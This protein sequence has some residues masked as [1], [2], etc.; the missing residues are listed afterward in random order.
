M[1]HL[2]Y[3]ETYLLE[4]GGY[5]TAGEIEGQPELWD[6]TSKSFFEQ[7]EGFR[8]FWRNACAKADEVILTGAGTSSFIGLSLEGLFFR[9]TGLVCRAVP[10]THI[11]SHPE[12]YFSK[13][14]TPLIVSFARSGNSP[15][16]CAALEAADAFS[17]SC[18]HLIITCDGE[19]SLAMYRS[20]HPVYT[21]LLPT[22]ANDKGLAMTG[23]YSS[24][25]L[26][27][28]LAACHTQPSYAEDQI[29]AQHEAARMV[30]TE[31][32]AQIQRI[33]SW[34]FKRAVFLGSGELFGTAEEAAL[35][36]QELT[37]GKIICKADTYLGFRHGPKAVIDAATLVV[38]F[39]NGNENVRRY[40]TDLLRTMGRGTRALFQLGISACPVDSGEL[41]ELIL[42][43]APV[44]M[45]E[46][47]MPL[48]AIVAAQLLAFFKSLQ[49]GLSPDNPSVSGAIS[50]VVEGVRI[51]PFTPPTEDI[52][53][54]VD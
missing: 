2:S 23:S 5:M 11:V 34:D 46:D 41:N 54:P 40:E 38:Y 51:Y 18:F 44:K 13:E 27:G 1:N 43:E 42:L 31:K 33:A 37:D 16:S 24:M 21:I 26:T 48:S 9:R 22:G 12:N 19:G 25:L 29:L 36:L 6:L 7:L 30:L 39:F 49:L 32:L 8:R 3:P 53:F 4:R 10:T 50:R 20:A 15:E 52:R 35:K 45:D 28:L 17:R 47:F 14:K